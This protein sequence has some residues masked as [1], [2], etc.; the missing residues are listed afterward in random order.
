MV[1]PSHL[2]PVEAVDFGY[3]R[4][5]ARQQQSD[6]GIGEVPLHVRSVEVGLHVVH[7]NQRQLTHQRQALGV[8]EPDQQRSDQPGPRGHRHRVQLVEADRGVAQCVG[9]YGIDPLDV[10]AAGDLGHHALVA[11]VLLDLGVDHVAADLDPVGDH[12]RGALVTGGLDAE[13][14]HGL[15]VDPCCPPPPGPLAT[16]SSPPGGNSADSGTSS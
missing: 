14:G 9:D 13:N 12:R 11:P 10:L 8:G 1:A 5:P 7:R 6:V 3:E 15:A 2:D 16:R 4:V